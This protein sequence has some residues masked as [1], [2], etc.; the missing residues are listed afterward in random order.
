VG[1]T[2]RYTEGGVGY[3]GLFGGACPVRVGTVYDLC[4]VYQSFRKVRAH[5]FGR[6]MVW[7]LQLD[8]LSYDESVLGD[9]G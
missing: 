4:R 2:A 8:E 6:V 5:G 1:G 7:S 3:D 9:S